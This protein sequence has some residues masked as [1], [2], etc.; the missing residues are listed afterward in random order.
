M[1]SNTDERGGGSGRDCSNGAWNGHV[2]CETLLDAFLA[3]FASQIERLQEVLSPIL[4]QP[5]GSGGIETAAAAQDSLDEMVDGLLRNLMGW[6]KVISMQPSM[7]PPPST[8]IFVNFVER[9]V[10]EIIEPILAK[11]TE[12]HGGELQALVQHFRQKVSQMLPK[13]VLAT[14]ARLSSH[15][16]RA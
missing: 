2:R 5:G 11:F 1:V 4:A 13:P 3:V 15:F 8:K 6:A 10:L 7:V 16:S 9:L 12:S 14:S